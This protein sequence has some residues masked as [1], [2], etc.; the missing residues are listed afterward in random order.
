MTNPVRSDRQAPLAVAGPQAQPSGAPAVCHPALLGPDNVLALQR[1][2]GNAAVGTLVVQRDAGSSPAYNDDEFKRMAMGSANDYLLS[3]EDFPP[4]MP[5]KVVYWK[6]MSAWNELD[7][8]HFYTDA[9]GAEQHV[10]VRIILYS[11]GDTFQL[12]VVKWNAAGQEIVVRRSSGW[13]DMATGTPHRGEKPQPPDN[14]P[15]R[16][17]RVPYYDDSDSVPA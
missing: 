10:K 11:R 6:T 1:I 4:A 12:R 3:G 16:P 7:E 2:A 5:G 14:S 9:N 8:D 13:I 17:D 15:T